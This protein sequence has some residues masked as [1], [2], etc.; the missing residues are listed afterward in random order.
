MD[1]VT[2][3]RSRPGGA[4]AL[5]ILLLGA[6]LGAA[7]PGASACGTDVR[8]EGEG[9][10]GPEA[11][12][13]ACDGALGRTPVVLASGLDASEMMVVGDHLLLGA[14]S[15][16]VDRVERCT[17]AVESIASL[18]SA[19][20][21]ALAEGGAVL[22]TSA[23]PPRL[24]RLD[25]D[26]TD[27]TTIAEL[28]GPGRVALDAGGRILAVLAL[29]DDTGGDLDGN[30]D[31]GL[32]TVD[33][34]SGE[35]FEHRREE[36]WLPGTWTLLGASE[37]GMVVR[38]SSFH[39]GNPGLLLVHLDDARGGGEL[40]GTHGAVDL[41]RVGNHLVLAGEPEEIGM[42][43]GRMEIVRMTPSGADREVLV[44]DSDD[45][46][47][48]QRIAADETLACWSSG[49]RIRCAE[50]RPGA[51]VDDRGWEADDGWVE[52][53]AVAPDAVYWLHRR[54]RDG[55][56]APDDVDLVAVAR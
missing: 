16:R 52:D 44:A 35:V 34:T 32:F 27:L 19:T 50:P 13:E 8:R 51:P 7:L 45:V 38:N 30:D 20:H 9:G 39:G 26:G 22:V 5:R 40:E 24:S 53:V 11:A 1:A 46:G 17:G 49:S 4:R 15:G 36:L 55:D 47:Y 14:P 23:S 42:G 33:P 29:P 2:L 37:A 54:D 43:S 18:G 41:A 25:R 3:P 28:P 12:P 21:L 10:A 6:A 56:G 48:V 31:V